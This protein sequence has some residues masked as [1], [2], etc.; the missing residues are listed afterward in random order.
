MKISFLPKT[1]SG[2]LSDYLPDEFKVAYSNLFFQISFFIG[3]LL[4]ELLNLIAKKII[5]EPRP[6][7]RPFQ[8]TD[9][10]MPSSHS[11]ICWFFA[12]YSTLF[13]LFRLHHN[14]QS[15]FEGVWKVT[16]IALLISTAVIVMYSR[17]YLLYHSWTQ[18]FVGAVVG[19]LL[20]ASWFFTVH[21][22]LTPYFPFIA[23]L[24]VCELLMI[25][26]TSLIPNILW[27]EYTHARSENGTRNRKLACMKTQ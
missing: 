5:R 23:S 25:R 3:S 18:V 19:I 16:V 6:L 2:I 7:V 1:F 11:Q 17:V 10:G 22:L 21:I 4:C 14:R 8:Q 13:I 20:G 9:F 15:L 27:F 12:I 24:S 26:D